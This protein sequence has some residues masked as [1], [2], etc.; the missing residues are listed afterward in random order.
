VSIRS[1]EERRQQAR[2]RLETDA[3]VWIATADADGTPHLVPLSLVWDGER[4]LVATPTTSRTVRNATASGRARLALD[5]ADDVVILD[6]RVEAIDFA[7]ADP[8]VIARYTARAGWDPRDEPGAWTLLLLTPRTVLAWRD[9]FE[10]PGRTIM[11][12]GAWID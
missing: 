5:S 11:R 8:D 7:A 2:H 1:T 4:V 12:D 3:N 6:T 9:V 10:I